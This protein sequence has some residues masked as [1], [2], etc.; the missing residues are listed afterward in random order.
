VFQLVKAEDRSTGTVSFKIFKSYAQSAGGYITVSFVIAIYVL[1]QAVRM[2]VDWWLS[3]W[4][5]AEDL[6]EVADYVPMFYAGIYIGLGAAFL[7]ILFVSRAIFYRSALAASTTIHNSVFEAVL[8]AKM[9]FFDTTP[10][11]R[12]VNRFFV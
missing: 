5:D 7:V 2:L 4:V 8:G 12:L 11:G 3:K 6:G 1:S 9:S 10:V